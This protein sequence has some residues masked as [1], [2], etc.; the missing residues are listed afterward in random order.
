MMLFNQFIPRYQRGVLSRSTFRL[1]LGAVAVLAGCGETSGTPTATRMPDVV[2]RQSAVGNSLTAKAC[3][4][5][6]WQGLVTSAGAPFVGQGD[7]VSY[8]AQGGTL[9]KAQTITFGAL[10]DKTF[11]DADFDVSATAS[12]GLTVSFTASGNC[13]ISGTTVH[14]VAAGSCTITA[15]QAGDAT[16]FAAPDVAQSF[17]IAKGNQSITFGAL[18]GKTFGDANFAV[19]ATASSG[20]TVAFTASGNCTVSG[21]TVQLTGAGSCTITASQSGDA[22][23]NAAVDVAQTFAI[24]KASQT[25]SFTSANPTPVNVGATYT[26]TATAT[27]GLPVA[28]TVAATS[29]GCSIAGGVVSFTSAGSCLVYANQVGNANYNAAAQV[30]QTITS[31]VP[32]VGSDASLRAAAAAGGTHNF[33]SANQTIVLTGGVVTV[34]TTLSLVPVPGSSATIDGNNATRIFNVTAS[35]NLTLLNVAVTKGHVA[36][37]GGG[38]INIAAGNVVLNGTSSITASIASVGGGVSMNGGSLTLNDNAHISNNQGNAEGRPQLAAAGGVEINSATLIMNGSSAIRN[39]L[40]QGPASIGGGVVLNGG[41]ITMNGLSTIAGNTT[42]PGANGSEDRKGGGIYWVNLG[43]ITMNGGATIT[44]N[45]APG[46]GGGIYRIT[47]GTGSITGA[48][49]AN[50]FSNSPNNCAGNPVPGCSN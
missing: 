45:S 5:G 31:V 3:Q 22:S 50:I 35:G 36:G 42:G 1:L 26:P 13:T 21:A 4:K 9:F 8:G 16:W 2:A 25:V 41:S 38:A 48:T 28:I 11:G 29:T 43:N 10:A 23:W 17:A 19:S 7:C 20:L 32:C 37:F 14:L 15:Q 39:N 12:S 47:G 30:Q 49:A 44:G 33:C 24:A 40:T 46:G 6:G 27:S 34:G 18:G